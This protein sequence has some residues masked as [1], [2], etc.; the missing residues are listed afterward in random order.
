MEGFTDASIDQLIHIAAKIVANQ[1]DMAKR[2]KE[3]Y[4]EK[5]RQRSWLWP[6]RR[7]MGRPEAGREVPTGENGETLWKKTSAPT[8]RRRDIGKMTA[9]TKK[10][11]R[12]KKK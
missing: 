8:V 9:L 4:L 6:S 3:K 1:E 5:Q 10:K 12:K 2:E 11:K 7:E